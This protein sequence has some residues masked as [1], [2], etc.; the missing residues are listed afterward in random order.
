MTVETQINKKRVQG[1][2][3]TTAI[4]YTLRVISVDDISVYLIT[5]A[6]NIAVLLT[7]GGVDY[8]A[9]VNSS[10][11]GGTVTTTTAYSSS[12][13]I[14]IL[15]KLGLTQTADLPTEGN[16]DEIS[17]EN[18][19]DRSRLIDIQQQ[20]EINRCLK[21]K[22]ED[23]LNT[24]NYAGLYMAAEATSD[25][26]S[27]VLQW[28]ATGDEL[29]AGAT[30]DE[31]S[32]AQ[33][34]ATNAS[35]SASAAASSASA[36]SSSASSASSSA[37]SASS[38]AAAAA[39]A[40]AEGMYNNVVSI[41]DTDSPYVPAVDE[42]GT[43][44]RID[45]T[46]GAV[47]INLSA[48][49]VYGEDMKFA[50]V[51]VAGS[52]DVTINRGGSDTFN[53]AA[54]SITISDSFVVN[55]IVGD[56]ATANWISLLHNQAIGAGAVGTTE[57]ADGAVTLAKMADIDASTNG[58]VIGR[59]SSNDVPVLIDLLDEDDMVSDSAS[60]IPTQQSVKAYVD[61][62]A[63]AAEE[64]TYTGALTCS[65]SGT[66]TLDASFTDVGYT[67][68]GLTYHVYGRL[69]VASVSSPNGALRIALPVAAADLSDHGGA[70]AANVK[71]EDFTSNSGD[72]IAII[73][74]GQAFITVYNLSGQSYAGSTAN[75]A[76]ANGFVHFSA[77]YRGA[78]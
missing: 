28:N 61:N 20:E 74:E 52:N 40:A 15:N 21:L 27:R 47:V 13:D 70:G 5:R 30:A 32:N 19:L 69:K 43:L 66:I 25:R 34:Y 33:T 41:D 64:G 29:E 22:T 58:K 39:S 51:R 24:T 11:T 49:S 65:V 54:T 44:Y 12:Y 75:D 37:S 78:S 68:V 77:T 48:L 17:V 71:I 6:T 53:S 35:A 36:A 14:L 4:P 2:G 57:L 63:A 76:A 73:G 72:K 46:N 8:T 16:F 42:E 10:G 1:D 45:T 31:I 50:F 56:S 55:S 7:G 38:Y 59:L 62:N 23:V 67:K 60:A 3:V 18:A 9:T 26:I